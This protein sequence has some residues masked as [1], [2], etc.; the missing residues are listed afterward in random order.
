[1]YG[2]MVFAMVVGL[3]RL[4]IHNRRLL[5]CPGPT[6]RHLL[7]ASGLSYARRDNTELERRHFLGGGARVCSMC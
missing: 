3:P 7:G 2:G 1:M 4:D 5:E 6:R